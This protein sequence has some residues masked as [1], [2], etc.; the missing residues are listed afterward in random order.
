[1]IRWLFGI[2]NR[3]CN[4]DAIGQDLSR[5]NKMDKKARVQQLAKQRE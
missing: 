3:V 1:M 2:A 4:W 5:E